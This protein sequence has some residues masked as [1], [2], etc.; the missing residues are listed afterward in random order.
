[1]LPAVERLIKKDMGGNN[2]AMK[3][4]IERTNKEYEL[5]KEQEKEE[6]RKNREKKKKETEEFLS[7]YKKH[8][9]N[10]EM[11]EKLKEVEPS[12]RKRINPVYILDKDFNIVNL[13]TSKNLIGNWVHE[14]G[15]SKKRLG[16][17]TIFEYIRNETL[18][19]DR[20]Y[21]VP[22]QNY[23]DFIDRKKLIKKVLL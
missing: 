6:R 4:H 17:T 2:E 10:N 12:L 5:K 22:S 18:Y 9:L 13:V 8:P 3:R 21:F 15:Y 23:D 11:V 19:K 16:R 1:M 20:F 7:F 14:N